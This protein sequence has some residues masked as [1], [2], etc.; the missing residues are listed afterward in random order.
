MATVTLSGVLTSLLLLILHLETTLSASS[1]VSF[2]SCLNQV[3]TL[4]NFEGT[5]PLPSHEKIH[6]L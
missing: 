6:Q 1:T 4:Y 5:K 2:R 3:Q